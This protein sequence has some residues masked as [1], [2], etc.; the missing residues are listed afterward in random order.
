MLELEKLKIQVFALTD[1]VESFAFACIIIAAAINDFKAFIK[2][3]VYID[4]VNELQ[5][6]LLRSGSAA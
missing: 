5:I 1:Y 6:P 4:I 3:G 2:V